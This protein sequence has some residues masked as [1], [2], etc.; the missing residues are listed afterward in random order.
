MRYTPT[1]EY[2]ARG[3]EAQGTCMV[4]VAADLYTKAG[5]L[6]FSVTKHGTDDVPQSIEPE[7]LQIRVV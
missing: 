1:P 6:P 3:K 5:S 4:L 2:T 7:S